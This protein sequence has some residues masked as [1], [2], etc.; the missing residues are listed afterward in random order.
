MTTASTLWA[1]PVL[2]PCQTVTE[3]GW[4]HQS[5]CTGMDNTHIDSKLWGSS[6]EALSEQ[7]LERFGETADDYQSQHLHVQSVEISL[8]DHIWPKTVCQQTPPSHLLPNAAQQL[9]KQAGRVGLLS[10]PHGQQ[11]CSLKSW[12]GCL[13][14]QDT[15]KAEQG[16]SLCAHRFQ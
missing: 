6:Q 3:R 4:F 12:D 14:P 13:L 11:L 9:W 7:S 8:W 10:F 1:A 15:A 16:S 5:A 2:F